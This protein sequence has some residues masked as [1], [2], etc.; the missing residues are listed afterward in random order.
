MSFGGRVSLFFSGSGFYGVVAI[1]ML[2][3][4]TSVLGPKEFGLFALVTAFTALGSAAAEVGASYI[5]AA[6]FSK[7]RLSE[8]RRLISTLLVVAAC[9]SFA[10]GGV[11]LFLWEVA[12]RHM[13]LFASVPGQAV[14][15]AV[16]SMILSVPWAI[17]VD[18]ITLEGKARQF[19]FV[20][21]A[22]SCVWA[23][24]ITVSLFVLK[25]GLLSLFAAA[26]A[27][28]ATMLV[29]SAV[30]LKSYV[31]LHCDRRWLNEIFRIGPRSLLGSLFY[32][33]QTAMERTV[34]SSHVGISQLGIYTH[35]QQYRTLI[36]MGAKAVSRSVW[37][38]TLADAHEERSDFARTGKAWRTV[39]LGITVAGIAFATVGRDIIALLTHDKFTDAYMLAAV[40]MVF[41]LV[42]NSGRPHVGVMY[43]RG[44]GIAYANMVLVT[45]VFS[46]GLLLLL[47][48]LLGVTGAVM[49]A[50]GQM[51]AFRIAIQFY[52]RGHRSVPFQDTWVIFGSGLVFAAL[53][54]SV[55]L[56][57][58]TL[59][60][61]F[62]FLV[63]LGIAMVAGRRVL[64]DV[65]S[66]SRRLF[67]QKIQA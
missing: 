14:A 1:L 23:I 49:A 11:L 58:S 33:I 61:V 22:Q 5:L 30:V 4:I 64:L 55:Y 60:S 45:T 42:Q 44:H 41:L 28:A 10:S 29:G 36:A 37:P 3:V 47:V 2:P 40:W 9:V 59:E 39:H 52:V 63:V 20:T 38:I 16:A 7:A 6:D 43:A 46:I 54:L 27:A 19:A 35:S 24:S 17:A 12:G 31:G 53:G 67:S 51:I 18:I 8:R 56:R 62:L 26:L 48:P 32:S 34:L 21:I 15:M 65:L 66:E 50:F 13:S 57:P 25:L